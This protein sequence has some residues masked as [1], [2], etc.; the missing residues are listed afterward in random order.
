MYLLYVFRFNIRFPKV[1]PFKGGQGFDP[2]LIFQGQWVIVQVQA[3][4]IFKF[5]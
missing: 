4:K 5:G 1:D 3:L 2:F